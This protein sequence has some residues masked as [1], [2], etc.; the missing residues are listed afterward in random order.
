MEQDGSD[1]D[2]DCDDEAD[3]VAV[4]QQEQSGTSG[5]P[6]KPKRILA[7]VKRSFNERCC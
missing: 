7:S 3:H 1:V 5:S 2:E 6:P 4:F